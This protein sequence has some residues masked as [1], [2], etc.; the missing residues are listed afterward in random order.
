LVAAS[1]IASSL[2]IP[3]LVRALADEATR[4]EAEQA[5]AAGGIAAF[6]A[7]R[8]T[9]EDTGT[10]ASLRWRIPSAMALCSAERTLKTL[11][12]WLPNEPD[13]GVRFGILIVLERV[14]RQN[15]TLSLDTPTLARSV[16][17]TLTRAYRYLDARLQLVRGAF[18]DAARKTPGH[19]L[20]RD[21]LRDKEESARQRLF[22]LLALLH[23]SEDLGQIYR[24]LSRGKEQRATSVELIESILREPVRSSVLG[25]VDDCADE[26]RLVRAGQYH[27]PKAQAYDALLEQLQKSESD[28]VR[29]VAEFHA[30]ELRL[31]APARSA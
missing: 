5:L 20:L 6:E 21:L 14:V 9:F 17:E 7:L 26:L 31:A 1:S 22:R 19:E 27:R 4:S 15:P 13:G 23:P 24:S 3:L 25:L 8:E 30:V 2:L 12:A 18:E 16:S 28:A 29:E 10:K 11:L